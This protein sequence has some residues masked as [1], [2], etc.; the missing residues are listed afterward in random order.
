MKSQHFRQHL[1][2]HGH[3]TEKGLAL[4]G[5]CS[6]QTPPVQGTELQALGKGL[7]RAAAEYLRVSSAHLLVHT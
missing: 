2:S 6:Q 1:H 4:L 3:A 5:R 7:C